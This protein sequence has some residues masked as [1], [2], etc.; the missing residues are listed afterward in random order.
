MASPG[1]EIVVV[2]D[3]KADQP[4]EWR[5]PQAGYDQFELPDLLPRPKSI[6]R[7]DVIED[8]IGK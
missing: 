6:S 1:L 5:D 7:D 4:R 3:H 8:P 2:D